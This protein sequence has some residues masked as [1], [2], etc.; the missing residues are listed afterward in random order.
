[1]RKIAIVLRKRKFEICL[2]VFMALFAFTAVRVRRYIAARGVFVRE[3]YAPS[4]LSDAPD[5][6]ESAGETYF[7]PGEG[8][9][10]GAYSPNVPVWSETMK[11]YAV[12]E[13]VDFACGPDGGV[14]ACRAGRVKAV[15]NDWLYGLT[16]TVE[17]EGGM[18]STYSSLLEASVSPGAYVSAGARI[19]LAGT[20]AACEAH[21]GKH[22]HFACFEGAV[23]VK[24]PFLTEE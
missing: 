23:P 3:R 9:M 4:A 24:P 11:S 1:M 18:V 21:L 22:V 16:V 8:A 6:E 20:S 12:H 13:G 19:G 7:L 2:C 5:E 14:Y 17:S 10:V 15:E